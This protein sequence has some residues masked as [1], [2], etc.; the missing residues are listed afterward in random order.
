MLIPE[1]KVIL[2]DLNNQPVMDISRYVTFT[3]ALKLND[4]STFDFEIDLTQFE[5]L[6]A[7][8][9]ATPR[10]IIYPDKT[11]VKVYRDNVALYGGI[12]TDADSTLDA[13]RTLNVKSASY[14]NYFANRFVSK[15]YTATDRSAIA[16]D[17]ID[18]V[19]SVANGDL[20]VTQGTLATI[21]SSD[22][23]CDYQDVKSIITLY[24]YAQPSTYDFEITPDKV[25]N[26]YTRLGSDKPSVQLSFPH[27]VNSMTIPRS[28]STLANKIIGIGSGIGDERIQSI[29]EDI[30]SQLNY[31]VV[32][33]KSTFNSVVQQTT[34]D[35]NTLGVLE[36]YKGVLVLPKLTLNRNA[37]NISEVFV[38]DSITCFA[39]G[40]TYNDDFNGLFRIYGINV[41]VDDKLSE[42]ITVDFYKPSNGGELE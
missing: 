9:G 31:R 29:Q 37:I 12:V 5:K 32:E 26:T 28:S 20:G 1:W 2:Y 6:C 25:F 3:L 42:T 13:K 10:N 30:P 14:L 38:G 11:E 16:W 7:N 23:T 33:K 18:T 15:T 41:T 4:V 40:S 19:Q 21:Y 36:D 27:N 22:L 17:A 35:Q 34:L 8:I 24:T 39:E